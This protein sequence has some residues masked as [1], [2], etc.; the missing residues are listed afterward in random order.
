MKILPAVIYIH[1]KKHVEAYALQLL[2]KQLVRHAQAGPTRILQKQ[3]V[4]GKFS[5]N[6][7]LP[8]KTVATLD[9]NSLYQRLLS[10]TKQRKRAVTIIIRQNIQEGHLHEVWN[11]RHSFL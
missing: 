5:Y 11:T 10:I 3:N 8:T 1:I 4:H 6:M 7:W 9:D 2:A